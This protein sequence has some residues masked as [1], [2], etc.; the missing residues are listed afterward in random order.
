LGVQKSGISRRI[1]QLEERLSSRLLQRTT[2]KLSLTEEGRVFHDHALRV[3][4]ELD[5]TERA[6]SGLRA[7]PRG[8]LRVTAPLSFGLLG[9][10]VAA[11]LRRHRDV[12]L[13]LVCTDRV[14]DLVEE[15]FDVAIRA[16]KLLDSSLVARRLGTL[17]RSLVASPEH[18]KRRKPPKAPGEVLDHPCLVF[19]SRTGAVW[20]LESGAQKVDLK[21]QGRLAVNDLDLLRA[22]TV[23]GLGIALLPH[24]GCADAIA[25]GRLVRVLPEWTSEENPIHAVYPSSRHLSS[26]VRAFVDFLAARLD[27]QQVR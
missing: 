2:R 7:V 19:G 9:A 8:I 27:A 23:S 26:K 4:A 12:Q 25:S 10:P 21:I 3:L 15:G 1:S 20:R 16:G 24:L 22:L 18:L 5:E 17:P 14:V 13:E 11:F 6:L